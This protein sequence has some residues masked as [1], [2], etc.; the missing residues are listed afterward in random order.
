MAATITEKEI[1]VLE[2]YRQLPPDD[3]TKLIELLQG[4]KDN[5]QDLTFG[6]SDELKQFIQFSVSVG[7]KDERFIIT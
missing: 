5:K 2:M 1:A 6:I 3:K 7:I 4:M